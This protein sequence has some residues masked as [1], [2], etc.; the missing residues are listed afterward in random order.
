MSLCNTVLRI[1]QRLKIKIDRPSC[2]QHEA[3]A[4][5]LLTARA[6]S[7]Y[8]GGVTFAALVGGS[9]LTNHSGMLNTLLH[10]QDRVDR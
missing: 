9:I 2:G 1:G 8:D 4:L 5:A 6:T 10:L 3:L 7:V